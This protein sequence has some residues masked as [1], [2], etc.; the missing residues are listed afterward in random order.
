MLSSFFWEWQATA[1]DD[2]KIHLE[3]SLVAVF[4]PSL[5]DFW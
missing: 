1:F 5:S 3:Q 4:L 2:I